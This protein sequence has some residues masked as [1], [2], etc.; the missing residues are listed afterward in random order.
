MCLET[1]DSDLPPER[2]ILTKIQVET[3]KNTTSHRIFY[4][5]NF[6]VHM[7]LTYYFT[8]AARIS[9]STKT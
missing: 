6:Q 1:L 5:L 3:E 7:F 2:E 9:N 8:R 4:L